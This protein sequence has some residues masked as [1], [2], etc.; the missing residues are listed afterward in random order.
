MV[1]GLR[2]ELRYLG[3]ILGDV[4]R[5][6]E[7]DE[8]FNLVEST[9]KAA[10]SIRHGDGDVDELAQKLGDVPAET[11]LPVIRA[12]SHFG[13]LANLAED[14][15]E[16]RIREWRADEGEPA[17]AATLEATWS[18]LSEGSVTAEEVSEALSKAQVAPVLTAHPTE[19]R[20]RTV[21]DVQWDITRL[22]RKRGRI[23][24]AGRTARS[25]DRLA[26]IDSSIR[27]RVSMLW[28]TALI[29]SVR[30]RIEDEINVGLR[31]FT[32]SLLQEIPVINRRVTVELRDRYGADLPGTPVVRPGSWIG[33]DHDGNPYVTGKTVTYATS[34]AAQTVFTW[35]LD[36]L[37]H[38]E[39]ELSLSSR[40]TPVPGDRAQPADAGHTTVPPGTDH[41][42][43]RA[44]HGIR[45]RVAATAAT[46][47][48]GDVAPDPVPASP[49]EPYGDAS[50]L[51]DDLET[52]DASLRSSADDLIADHRLG[53]VITAARTFG[54]HLSSL[55]LRQNSESFEEILGEL[56][57]RAG[58]TGAYSA[59]DEGQRVELL[60]RE[61]HSPRPLTDR[62]ARWSEVTE[63]ELGIFRSAADA[64]TRYG[65]DA[66]PHCIISMA[67]S[68]SDILEPMILLKEVGLIDVVDQKLTGTVDVIPLFETIDDLANGA[69]VMAELWGHDF[70]RDYVT[71]RGNVQEIMLGYSDSN[72][73]GGYFAANWGLYDAELA[74]VAAAEDAGVGLR[75]F[76]GRGGTVGRGGGPSHEAILAQPEGAVQ[77]SV[78]ITEQG[79]I[80]S[81][82]YGV[83]SVAR[84]SLETLVSATLEA[85]LLPVDRIDDPQDAYRTMRELAELSRVAYARLMHEDG[86]FIGYFTSSTPLEE[87]G[88][89]N[90]GS[91]PSSRKQTS[92]ISDLRAIPWV[93]SW[94][95]SR[96]MLPGWFG[97]G[98]ALREWIGQ[99]DGDGD[100][101]RLAYL[102]KLHRDWP[103]FRSVLSNMAQVMA[104]A[105]LSVAHLYSGLVP[106]REDAERIYGMIAE[107]FRLTLDIYL[108]ITGQES[109]V[110]DNPSLAESVRNRFPYLLPLNLLQLELLRK[111]REGDRSEDVLDGIRLTMNGL[112][113]G[114]RNSG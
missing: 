53:D 65:A 106:D 100:G 64:V 59:L 38:L 5:E 72:K 31:Y 51:I 9:R 57:A 70:Y 11:A 50:E 81:A 96:I 21:F 60:T 40:L 98:S 30:P 56:F 67:S 82:K 90:I 26:G 76:H 4:V 55:D 58:V 77:G 61:L 20:R 3:A 48:T 41:P 47:L 71:Q 29:R 17:P 66:V 44:V 28:Q 18:A 112:A 63:R 35:Y 99:T 97:V 34:R 95:Q 69:G 111:Y 103:F 32:I 78:R 108:R 6:Q 74:L 104:K 52:I 7:G 110:S 43:R 27:R 49:H 16:E 102:Q 93:L 88:N 10:F 73:D 86:G 13:L 89:L 46:R 87:I 107:E 1:P 37:H 105:D 2:Q 25:D 92:S 12:F 83:P 45:G 42:S 62:R 8:V 39:H 80:I 19:T 91:R 113:T 36:Q 85:S 101:D 15:H 22:M 75:L 84:R 33:G 68:V 109:L 24:N 94:S 23:L 14:L 114:L 54:F 79:E